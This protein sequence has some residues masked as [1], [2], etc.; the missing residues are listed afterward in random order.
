MRIAMLISSVMIDCR[1]QSVAYVAKFGVLHAEAERAMA[2]A[3]R[4]RLG[5][6]LLA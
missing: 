3:A 2:P 6:R 1:K 5:G 4:R